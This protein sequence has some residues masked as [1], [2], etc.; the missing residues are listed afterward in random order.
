M[1]RVWAEAI[2]TVPFSRIPVGN[3]HLFDS[4]FLEILQQA[5]DGVF[6]VVRRDNHRN[7]GKLGVHGNPRARHDRLAVGRNKD[8][9]KSIAGLERSIRLHQDKIKAERSK[10]FPNDG[11]IAH[12][13]AEIERF[14]KRKEILTRRLLREW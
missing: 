5:F 1:T 7:Q 8:L 2:S 14:R 10:P 3:D 4:K 9:R 12:W 13:E 11:S 6:L